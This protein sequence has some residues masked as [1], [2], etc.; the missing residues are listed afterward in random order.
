MASKKDTQSIDVIRSTLAIGVQ[1]YSIYDGDGRLTSV[2]EAP[3]GAIAGTP[4]LLTQ[5]KYAPSSTRV[6]GTKETVEEWDTAW[7][8]DSL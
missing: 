2:Y 4:C 3:T 5:F 6:I 8:F 1:T 7:D